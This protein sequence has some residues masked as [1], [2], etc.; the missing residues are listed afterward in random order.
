MNA[1]ENY[2]K[3]K[4]GLRLGSEGVGCNHWACGGKARLCGISDNICI[5]NF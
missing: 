3:R 1:Y 5:D 2:I 4:K